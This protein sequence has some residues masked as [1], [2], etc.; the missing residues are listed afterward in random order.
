MFDPIKLEVY[1][2]VF[3]SITDEMGTLLKLSSFSP[4]IKERKDY[5]AALFSSSAEIFALGAHIP[6]HLGAMPSSV[7]AA[8]EE[9]ELEEGDTAIL[10]HPF[11]GGTHLPDIT[12][13]SPVFWR[14]KPVFYVANRAHHSD[15]GGMQPGSMPLA[16]EIYQEGLIIPPVKVEEGGRVKGDIVKIIVA[17][18][19]NPRE[20]EAD[21]LAQIAANRKAIHRLRDLLERKGEE[22]LEYAHH[23]MDYSERILR[24]RI[25]ELPSGRFCFQDFLDDDGFGS[26]AIEVKVCLWKEGDSLV[27]DFEGTSPQVRGGVNANPAITL[28]AVLYSV[29]LML[30]EDLPVNSGILRPVEVKIPPGSLLNPYP[31]AAVAGGN[32]ETSQRIVDVLLGAFSKMLPQRAVAASQGTMN[33]ISFGG[34][35]FAYYE[36]IGG[37]AGATAES[38]GASGLHT[39]MTNSMN[40]PVEVL[41]REIPVLIRR[42][43]LRKGSGGRGKKRG[44]EGIVREY[45]FLSPARVSILSERRRFSPYGLSGG[46]GGKPGGNLLIENGEVKVLPSKVNF[47]VEKGSRLIV[48]TPGGGGY[49]KED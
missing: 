10:N 11:Y 41:E 16:E 20:R 42:Y 9:I 28:S 44:G 37:G 3:V 32:V 12:V 17:N 27:V 49:G 6:V 26:Q 45:E 4:N 18:S 22:A 35:G 46:E 5:S 34:K 40:T 7:A 31:P 19:R 47:K 23:L 14:G 38:H 24:K 1:R 33:N 25:A 21:L 13:I 15:V 2:N 39:H 48:E 30:G 43:E 8:L 36:T 29:K